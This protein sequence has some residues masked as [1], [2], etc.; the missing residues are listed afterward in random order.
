MYT[1][2]YSLLDFLESPGVARGMAHKENHYNHTINTTNLDPNFLN[3]FINDINLQLVAVRTPLR[4]LLAFKN[5][6]PR[7]H[8]I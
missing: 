7:I 6:L 3:L 8:L 1:S 4:D 2:I 5:T